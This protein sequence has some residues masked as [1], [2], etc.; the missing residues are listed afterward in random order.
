MVIKQKITS[1]KK[2]ENKFILIFVTNVNRKTN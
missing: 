1:T 2:K